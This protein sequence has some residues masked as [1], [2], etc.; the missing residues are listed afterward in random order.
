MGN[1][2]SNKLSQDQLIDL[3]SHSN[4]T[5]REIEE[6]YQ[7][8]TA[9]TTTTPVSPV[10]QG[11]G[12]SSSNSGTAVM[13][14]EKFL[15]KCKNNSS[16][17]CISSSGDDQ[18]SGRGHDKEA[19]LMNSIFDNFVSFGTNEHK[20]E[21]KVL[22]QEIEAIQSGSNVQKQQEQL[23]QSLLSNASLSPA[24]TLTP[25]S[26]T[27]LNSSSSSTMTN[28]G[29]G[30]GNVGGSGGGGNMANAAPIGG[31]QPQ[32]SNSGPPLSPRSTSSSSGGNA[33]SAQLSSAGKASLLQQQQQYQALWQK[34]QEQQ[35]NMDHLAFQTL[36]P[37][38]DVYMNGN[39]DGALEWGFQLFANP[40]NANRLVNPTPSTA[41]KDEDITRMLTHIFKLLNE[42]YI[43]SLP[44]EMRTPEACTQLV[45][46]KLQ[47]MR[48][49]KSE[50]VPSLERSG[51]EISKKEFV[52][53]CRSVLHPPQLDSA[54]D[55]KDK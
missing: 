40:P 6:W 23:Y 54:S 49:S 9:M 34:V 13:T 7:N 41:I 11:G 4:F 15:A 37:T 12:S 31:G 36:L 8:F 16:N 55:S 50:L 30:S 27:G 48:E 43:H 46:S 1:S 53:Y 51:K 24:S 39:V 5:R 52:E 10:H 19:A 18:R 20:K 32:A 33:N 14:R 22:K 38:I 28:I 44:A 25:N 47:A 35:N 29:G 42:K 3:Q 17:N 26:A 45:L 21:M 2:P